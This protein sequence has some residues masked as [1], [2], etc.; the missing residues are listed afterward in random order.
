MLREIDEF[1]DRQLE[2]E[3]SCFLVLRELIMDFHL[4]M[5][6]VMKYR[7]PCFTLKSKPFCYLWKDKKTSWPYILVVK[8]NLMDHSQLQ[9]GERSKMKRFLIDPKKDLD[10][11]TIMEILKEASTFYK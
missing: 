11:K 7:M 1:Y 9:Q 5:E 4:D 3:R 8:G 2:P 10:L 6:H